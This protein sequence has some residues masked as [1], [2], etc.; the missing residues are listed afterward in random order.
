M[1]HTFIGEFGHFCVSLA[2]VSS[3]LAAIAYFIGNYAKD[4]KIFWARFARAN[5]AVHGLSVLGII[6]ALFWIIA[7]HYYEYHYAWSHSSNTLPV[8]YMISCFWEGQ[9]GSFLLWIFWHVVLATILTVRRGEWELPVMGVFM[10]VQAFLVSMILG[11]VIPILELKIGSTPFLLLRDAMPDTPIFI[12]NPDFVPEDGNGLNALLQ[13]YWMVIHPPTL[14]LGFAAS[15]VPFAF[16]MAAMLNGKFKTWIKPTFTWTLFAAGILGLG[17]MMGAYWAYETLNFGGYWSWD[18]VENAVYI[19]WLILVGAAHLMTASQR[20]QGMIRPAALLAVLSFILI[21]YSTFLTR[22]GIL[23]NASVH[24]FT[25][26]GLS[27]QLLIYML[28]FASVSFYFLIRTWKDFPKSKSELQVYDA[29]FWLFIGSIV[30]VLTALQVFLPTS[31]PVFNAIVE[32]LG[33]ESN[34][35]PPADA[36]EFYGKWQIWFGIAIALLSATGQFF[37]WKKLS[38]ENAWDAFKLPFILTAVFTTIIVSVAKIQDWRYVVL[39]LASIYSLVS[40]SAV[41]R[42]IFK[43][44]FKLSGGAIAHI[45]VALMLLGVLTSEGYD[46]IVSLNNTGLLYNREFSDEMN[47]ENLLLFRNQPQRMQDF[48]LTYK[49]IRMQAVDFPEY[50]DKEKLRHTPV[51]HLKIAETDF[52]YKSEIRIEKGDTL[53]VFDEN[54]Y[55]EIEFKEPSGKTFTLFPRVQMNDQMGTVVSPDVRKFWN[56]DLYTHLTSIPD[57]DQEVTWT[58]I[59]THTLHIGDT[60]VVNDFIATLKDVLRG[61]PRADEDVMVFARIEVLDRTQSYIAE[62]VYQIK[63]NMV[64]G[65]PEFLEGLGIEFT[66]EGLDPTTGTFT[67][68]TRS[69]QRDWVIMKA[70]EK[71]HINLLWIGTILVTFGFGLAAWRRYQE[72]QQKRTKLGN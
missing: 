71:P 15:L 34:L 20:N 33:F 28:F 61:Q 11:V 38:K 14:F 57:P 10:T 24:S 6:F 40:N 23:G 29:T 55:Y 59:E 66:L 31:I 2:F 50:I 39:I 32:N 45:G 22:S 9:E 56:K 37:W 64:R 51:P 60:F 43:Q 49:G 41:I 30:L 17:I 62:P 42:R 52:I 67:V 7:N 1:I 27:G 68:R 19:P 8:E 26:L 4:D 54:N 36:V 12:T 63:D 47:K 25:D 44:G 5:F 65:I 3:I 21:L 35:A 46:R 53:Q 70:V 58:D 72:A 69:T 13:N 18:P 16:V 48:T